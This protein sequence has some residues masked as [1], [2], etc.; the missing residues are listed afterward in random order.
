ME[1]ILLTLVIQKPGIL[2][3]KIQ[4]ELSQLMF[5]SLLFVNFCIKVGFVAKRWL[6]REM[7][8]LEVYL[9]FDMSIYNTDM[10]I[11]LDETGSDLL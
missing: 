5:V 1:L 6:S 10:L 11:F 2:L 9:L 7:N 4:T 3:R 8:T